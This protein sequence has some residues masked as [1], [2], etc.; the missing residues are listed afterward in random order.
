MVPGRTATRSWFENASLSWLISTVF[1]G[2]SAPLVPDDVPF[3]TADLQMAHLAPNARR[4]WDQER[5]SKR[6]PS[7]MRVMRTLTRPRLIAGV[8]CSMF[9]GLMTAV[10]RPVLLKYDDQRGC[11][12]GPAAAHRRSCSDCLRFRFRFRSPHPSQVHGG[13]AFHGGVGGRGHQAVARADRQL[14]RRG[15]AG[16]AGQAHPGREGG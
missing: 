2:Y 12:L 8:I 4:L 16:G 15:R 14:D 13:G 11:R 6:K 1:K 3:T 10:M 9:Q 5:T 7:L